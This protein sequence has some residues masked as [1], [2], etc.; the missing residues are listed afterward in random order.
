VALVAWYVPRYLGRSTIEM[1]KRMI[2]EEVPVRTVERLR[3]SE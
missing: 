1:E 2:F 3:L